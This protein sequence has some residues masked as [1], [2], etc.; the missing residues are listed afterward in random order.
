MGSRFKGVDRRLVNLLT[1]V[2]YNNPERMGSVDS[3]WK[4]PGDST[5]M[6][7]VSCPDISD[8][9]ERM[10]SRQTITLDKGLLNPLT[11]VLHWRIGSGWRSWPRTRWTHWPMS[12]TEGIGSGQR[13]WTRTWWLHWP[14]FCTVTTIKEWWGPD[15]GPGDSTDQ[16]PV[17]TQ[18]TI[19]G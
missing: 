19:K 5:D 13:G 6:C 3:S 18:T 15:W 9:H 17:L 12:C 2:L 11:N 1:C 16:S 10:G 14:L 7:P 8:N 4:G